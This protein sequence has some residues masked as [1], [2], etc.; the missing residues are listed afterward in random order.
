MK[1]LAINSLGYEGGGA[2]TYLVKIIPYLLDKGYVIKTLASDL[3]ADK[4][5]FNE[6]VFKSI[7]LDSPSKILFTL[8]NPSSFFVL[9]RVLKEYKPDIIHLHIMH[10]ITPSALLLLKK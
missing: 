9:K 8:F 6:Y 5:H 2:E 4:K 7:N 3:G 1:V 10:Q